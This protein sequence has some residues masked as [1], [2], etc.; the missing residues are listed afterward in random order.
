V[1]G[2]FPSKYAGEAQDWLIPETVFP[3]QARRR[4]E[5]GE[6][7][8]RR[9]FYVALTRGKDVVYLSRFRKKQNKFQPSPFLLEVAGSD[10]PV[11]STLPLPEPFVPPPDEAEELPTISFSELAAYEG[12]PLRY[13]F[14]SSLG[15]QPQLVTE[16]GYGRAI[17]H[18]LRRVAEVAKAKKKLPTAADIAKVFEEGFY[19]P[20]ANNA[21][22]DQLF[23]RARALVDKYLADYS[24]DL[25]RVWETERHFELHLEKG[26]V[27]GRAD[28]ILDRE[29]GKINRLALVDYKTANDPKADDIFGFQLAIYASAGRGEGLNV[30][31]AYLHHLKEGERRGVPVDNVAVKVARMRA[32]ILIEGIVGGEFPARPEK[33]KCRSC[34]MRAICR[35][36]LC[37]KYD[38]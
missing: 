12:C 9:L 29:G 11:A 8:E 38:L 14:S 17:H 30:D 24:S 1:Q 33:S 22:F 4:Y 36:A 15:F 34:D 25:L 20:F 26:I 18:I 3:Q 6:V 32:D 13:R 27:S 19:L 23:K 28:V 21:A 37:G 7:E 5:G 10:P 16:L 2:R 31:A 35:H